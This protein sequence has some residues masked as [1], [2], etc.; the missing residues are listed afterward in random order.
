MPPS[1]EDKFYVQSV[2]RALEIIEKISEANGHGISVTEISRSIGL[3]VSTVYRLIQNLQAWNYVHENSEGNYT[4]GL[5]LLQLG[6]IVLR[7]VELRNIAQKYMEELNKQ[8]KETIYM[9]ILDDKAYELIYVE[10]I[11]SLRNVTLVAGVG[12]RNYVHSTANGKCILSGFSDE[13]IR[14]ILKEKRYACFN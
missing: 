7:N 9:A 11:E 1:K 3:P 2:N 4:L 5:K 10:K 8:T 6:S 14:E 12:T 13:K